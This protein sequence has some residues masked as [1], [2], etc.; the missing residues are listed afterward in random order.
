MVAQP[1][2]HGNRPAAIMVRRRQAS[3]I[4]FASTSSAGST[5][6]VEIPIHASAIDRLEQAPRGV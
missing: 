6:R 1:G 2:I 5:F 3:R 4:D